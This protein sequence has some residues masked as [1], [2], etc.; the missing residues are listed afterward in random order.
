MVRVAQLGIV[1]GLFGAMMMLV[2]LFPPII[3]FADTPGFGV[4][5]LL[6]VL[7]G[8]ALL[9]LGALIYVRFTFY[10]RQDLTLAQRIGTRLAF[11]GITFAG[12]AMFA[13]VLGFGSNLRLDGADVLLGPL[14]LW[15]ILVSFGVASLGVLIFAMTG[16]PHVTEEE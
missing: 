14:Q 12:L 9:I 6:I 15:G 16:D 11:T 13:D 8:F 10:A 3:G 7:I 5:Q 4:I 2:G 1:L